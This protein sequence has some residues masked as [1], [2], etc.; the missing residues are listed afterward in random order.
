MIDKGCSCQIPTTEMLSCAQTTRD[1]CWKLCMLPFRTTGAFVS[2]PFRAIRSERGAESRFDCTYKPHQIQT[3]RLGSRHHLEGLVH[4]PGICAVRR[5]LALHE[6]RART[7]P[8]DNLHRGRRVVLLMRNGHREPYGRL[9]MLIRYGQSGRSYQL[10]EMHHR[11]DSP[12]IKSSKSSKSAPDSR[13]TLS[14][15]KILQNS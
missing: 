10:S 3:V 5:D 13:S 1:T 4:D 2:L 7:G 14:A 15:L 9:S 12:C 8:E 6:G 11:Y